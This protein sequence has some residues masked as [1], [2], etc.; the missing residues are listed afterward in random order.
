MMLAV[1]VGSTMLALSVLGVFAWA[2]WN[3]VVDTLD[4]GDA[5]LLDGILDDL[6]EDET[7]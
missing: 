3:F 7:A 6:D 2:C 5:N 1:V 4:L